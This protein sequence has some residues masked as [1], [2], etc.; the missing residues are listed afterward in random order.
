MKILV[1]DDDRRIVK[2]TCD[3]L[4]I[5]GYETIAA[6]T[7]EEA[8]EIAKTDLPDCVLMDIKMPGI[9]GV[10]AMEQMQLITPDLPVVL[11]SAYASNEMTAE[12][13]QAGAYA[14]LNKPI[15]FQVIL[16]FLSLLRKEESILIVDDDPLFCKTL[17]D[18]LILRGYRVETENSSQNVLEHMEKSYKLVILLDLKLGK[19]N[20]LDV[21]QQIRA[22][23]PSKPVVLVTGYRNEMAESIEK[24]IMIGAY[25]SLYKPFET[26]D[27]LNLI[28]EIRFKKLQNLLVTT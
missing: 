14:V 11:I 2:T 27:L 9:S 3:I 7:G 20:G 25:T 21:L 10:E 15:N 4:K 13:K 1:V 16:S 28:E 24:G 26:E 8:V 17:K 5:K 23:Y 12:A 19:E 22:K 18:I 6:Y